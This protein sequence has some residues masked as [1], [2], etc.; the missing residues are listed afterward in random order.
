MLNRNTLPRTPSMFVAHLLTRS[1]KENGERIRGSFCC[2]SKQLT[3][4]RRNN[5]YT[6]NIYFVQKLMGFNMQPLITHQGI[7]N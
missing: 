2:S 7:A 6:Q 3:I 1:V 5:L 4:R